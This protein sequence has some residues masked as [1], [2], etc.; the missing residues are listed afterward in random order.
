MNIQSS[1]S[2]TR[3]Q[4]TRFLEE[5]VVVYMAQLI[6]SGDLDD[7]GKLLTLVYQAIED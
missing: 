5:L 6:P 3:L 7:H 1:K 4:V 2:A